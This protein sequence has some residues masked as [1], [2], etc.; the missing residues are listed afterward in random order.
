MAKI[1]KQTYGKMIAAF[2]KATGENYTDWRTRFLDWPG[3]I[4]VGESEHKQPGKK[5]VYLYPNDSENLSQPYFHTSV[6]D[7]VM[8]PR[9]IC[10][11]TENS[12]YIF[13]IGDFGISEEEKTLLQL[14]VFFS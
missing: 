7:I 14:N 6:G 12:K 2:C 3:L 4:V 1:I 11:E 10:I 8:D 13:E 9:Y 5:F